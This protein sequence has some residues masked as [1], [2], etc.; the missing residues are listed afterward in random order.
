MEFLDA[1]ICITLPET[2]IAPEM[3]GWNT[4]F[5]L[6]WPMFRG[7]NVSFREGR[8]PCFIN[9]PISDLELTIHRE[10]PPDLTSAFGLFL[11]M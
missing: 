9:L 8:V 2:N 1:T 4:N 11:Y 6:G 5:L 7:G 10:N 3:D